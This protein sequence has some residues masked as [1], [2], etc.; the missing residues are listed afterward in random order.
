[1]VTDP[2]RQAVVVWKEGG[3]TLHGY[4]RAVGLDP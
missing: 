4:R 3:S 1:V 2:L